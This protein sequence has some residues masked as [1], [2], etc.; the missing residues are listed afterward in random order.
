MIEKIFEKYEMNVEK[1][2]I[3]KFNS[4]YIHENKELM[5]FY[6]LKIHF[7]LEKNEKKIHSIMEFRF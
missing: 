4:S 1:K 6:C 7:S 2:V 5:A 3:Y